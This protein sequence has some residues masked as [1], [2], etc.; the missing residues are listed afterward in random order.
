MDA[1]TFFDTY[2]RDECKAV[3]TAAGT[4]Y[5]Y[6]YQLVTGYRERCSVDLAQRLVKASDSRLDLLALLGANE[7]A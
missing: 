5:A 7:A 6:F 3:A 1:K 2:G 4:N